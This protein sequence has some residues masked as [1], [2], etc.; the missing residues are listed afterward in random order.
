MDNL[1][2]SGPDG[3]CGD[4]DNGQ[5]SAGFVFSSLGFYPVAPV[6]GEYIIG[7]PLF[8]DVTIKLS[9]GNEINIKAEGNSKENVFVDDIQLNGQAFDDNWFNHSELLNG[10]KIDFKMSKQPNL[11]RGTN[12]DITPF[13]MS[14]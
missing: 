1:Y 12:Q 2:G 14:K 13:S 9:N 4:E 7:S 5:T 10:C 11:K 6:T 3:Y 8:N